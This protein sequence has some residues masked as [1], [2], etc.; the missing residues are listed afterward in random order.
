MAR[1]DEANTSHL[2][3]GSMNEHSD[4]IENTEIESTNFDHFTFSLGNDHSSNVERNP[5]FAGASNSQLPSTEPCSTPCQDEASST[6][7]SSD[8]LLADKLENLSLMELDEPVIEGSTDKDDALP[9]D[10]DQFVRSNLDHTSKELGDYVYDPSSWTPME[11]ATATGN[12]D[13]TLLEHPLQLRSTYAEVE[14]I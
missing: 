2:N 11:I 5:D 14:V 6:S 7:T 9:S 1:K 8:F 13:C 10:F 12:A 3:H 4:L